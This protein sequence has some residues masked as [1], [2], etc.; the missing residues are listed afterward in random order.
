MHPLDYLPAFCFI[1]N[2]KYLSGCQL[3]P[4]TP[5]LEAGRLQIPLH[6]LH[7]R[8]DLP[9]LPLALFPLLHHL[10]QKRQLLLQPAVRAAL[11]LL[12]AVQHV[13]KVART[14]HFPDA[15]QALAH[16]LDVLLDLAGFLGEGLTWNGNGINKDGRDYC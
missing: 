9:D 6:L 14:A 2:L 1:N 4:Q 12:N 7:P 16:V 15:L 8:S 11:V 5:L 13:G 10:L 3:I